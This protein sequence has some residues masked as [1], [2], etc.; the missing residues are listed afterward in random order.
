MTVEK[1]SPE[2]PCMDARGVPIQVGDLIAYGARSGNT[3]SISVKYVDEIVYIESAW[4]INTVT[5]AKSTPR[6]AFKMR[7][8]DEKR[9]GVGRGTW[10]F[11]P[12]RA[13]VIQ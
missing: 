2:P 10:I 11:Y 7:C 1:L 3:G 6:H 5:G 12:D 9:K 13:V 4:W 8:H